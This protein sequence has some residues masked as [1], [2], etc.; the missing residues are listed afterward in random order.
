MKTTLIAVALLLAPA[1]AIA[2]SGGAAAGAVP[3]SFDRPAQ[4]QS[5]PAPSAPTAPAVAATAPDIARSEEALRA[6]IAAAQGPGFDYSVFTDSLAA[7]I[8]QQAD[9]V[10]PLVKGFGA[11]KTVAFERPEGEAHL[12]KVTFDNQVTEWVIGFDADDKIAALLFR[13]VES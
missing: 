4:A 8:R 7:Q 6:V 5:Q 9:Q 11:V 1:S 10:A 12:F 3:N 13:P 2:Q